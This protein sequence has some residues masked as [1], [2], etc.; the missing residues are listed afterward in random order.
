MAN[1]S[2]RFAL[3]IIMQQAAVLPDGL[4]RL[5]TL[6]HDYHDHPISRH[7][8]QLAAKNP[9]AGL[10][11]VELLLLHQHGSRNYINNH[12]VY[13]NAISN[14]T[15]GVGILKLLLK[16]G[17]QVTETMKLAAIKEAN[18]LEYLAILLE[19]DGK[20]TDMVVQGA[21]RN[22]AKGVQVLK[23]LLEHGA[24]V[25]EASTKFA[26]AH[27]FMGLEYMK[28]LIEYGA[29]VDDQILETAMRNC[30]HGVGI[31]KLLLEHGARVTEASMKFAA[32]LELIDL[33]DEE[34]L[35]QHGNKRNFEEIAFSDRQREVNLIKFLLKYRGESTEL[36]PSVE[37]LKLLLKHGGKPSEEVMVAAV[38][39]E[40]CGP[41]CCEILLAHGGP[42]T[43]DVMVSAIFNENFPI[44]LLKILIAHGGKITMEIQEQAE[45]PRA[46]GNPEIYDF[47]EHALMRQRF[48][49]L[50]LDLAEGKRIAE[51][52]DECRGFYSD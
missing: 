13:V 24:N 21:M 26:A 22:R 10:K 3:E 44:K 42:I 14:Q 39:N 28:L 30:T 8:V 19:Y 11:I 16:L 41:Q 15:Q 17:C 49:Q 52:S 31:L 37:Y 25:T 45:F 33:V 20:I 5:T 18:S 23:L 43:E 9:V 12:E 40:K 51:I 2:R 35:N 1:P 29:K 32:G 36:L 7:T 46:E 48:R 6:L 38:D 50:P 4:E 47:L 27:E 34:I